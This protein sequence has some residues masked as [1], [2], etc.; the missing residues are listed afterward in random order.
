MQVVTPCVSK[1]ARVPLKRM[2]LALPA[3]LFDEIT[4]IVKSAKR[5]MSEVDFVRNAAYE[6]AVRYREEH[7]GPA[8]PDPGHLPSAN[9]KGRRP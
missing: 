4:A 7:P 2:N 9:P 3:E 6:A 8:G 5:W 1:G